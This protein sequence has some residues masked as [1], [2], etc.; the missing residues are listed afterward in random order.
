MNPVER[1]LS[2]YRPHLPDNHWAAIRGLVLQ[3]A[4]EVAPHSPEKAA[5]LVGTLTHYVHWCW[6]T[7]GLEPTEEEV[8]TETTLLDYLAADHGENDNLMARRRRL[9]VEA[10]TGLNGTRPRID[11]HRRQ[12]SNGLAPYTDE[13][14]AR[15]RSWA[16]GQSSHWQRKNATVLLA[17]GAGCG[18]SPAEVRHAKPGDYAVKDGCPGMLVEGG[19]RFV[20]ILAEWEDLLDQAIEECTT[21]RLFDSNL[22]YREGRAPAMFVERT[23]GDEGK[24]GVKR[25]RVTWFVTQLR[26]GVP[27]DVIIRAA[28]VTPGN[29]ARHLDHV[30]ER[31]SHESGPL[32]RGAEASR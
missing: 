13:E 27:V 23:S 11:D 2:N 8:F 10:I 24:P 14:L 21:E 9:L 20:P 28:G 6:Q 7:A 32:L 31:P 29:L 16:A 12:I 3:V 19:A 25:L 15:F 4:R 18:F 5:R 1:Y 17:L 22:T 26:R 30:P